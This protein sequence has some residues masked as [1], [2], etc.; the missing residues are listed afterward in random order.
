MNKPGVPDNWNIELRV[1]QKQSRLSALLFGAS[2]CCLVLSKMMRFGGLCTADVVK[3]LS[4]DTVC[5]DACVIA[6]WSIRHR[7]DATSTQTMLLLTPF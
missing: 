6:L 5:L 3:H 2:F 4:N 7:R 1:T